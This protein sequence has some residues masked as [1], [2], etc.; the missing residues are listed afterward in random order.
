MATKNTV[1]NFRK[2]F[3]DMRITAG[4]FDGRFRTRTVENQR[5]QQSKISCRKFK[6]YDSDIIYE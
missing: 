2:I 3:R 5:A 4:A 6:Q 1:K